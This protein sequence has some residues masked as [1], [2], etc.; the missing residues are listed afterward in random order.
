MDFASLTG[1][2]LVSMETGDESWRFTDS[3]GI[4]YSVV[5]MQDCCESVRIIHVHGESD[6]VLGSPITLAV[7]DHPNMPA[8][9]CHDSYTWTRY[10]LATTKGTMI[11][12]WLGESNGWYGETPRFGLSQ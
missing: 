1:K 9:Q 10:T 12:E 2:T 5:H 7:E 6:R 8:P 11:V 3:D 4:G